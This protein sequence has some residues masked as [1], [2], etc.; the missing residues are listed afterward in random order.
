MLVSAIKETGL[1]FTIE[2]KEDFSLFCLLPSINNVRYLM[3]ITGQDFHVYWCLFEKIKYDFIRDIHS[4]LSLPI[5]LLSFSHVPQKDHLFLSHVT[6]HIS[7]LCSARA[8][9][10]G[11]QTRFC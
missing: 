3:A 1:F 8:K 2:I 4:D 11:P 9:L 6:N 7:A 10:P 5:I